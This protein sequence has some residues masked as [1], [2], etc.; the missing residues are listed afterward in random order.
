MKRPLCVIALVIAAAVLILL[1]VFPGDEYSFVSDR[2]TITIIGTVTGK[3]RKINSYSGELQSIVELKVMGE[4]YSVL[5]YMDPEK[6][7]E[8]GRAIKIKG[9]CRAFSSATNPG[10]FD[11]RSYYRI[12]K[13]A[14]RITDPEILEMSA[15]YDGVKESLFSLKLSMENILDKCMSADDAGVMKAVLLGDKSY[16]DENTRDIYKR[17]GIIHI[18]AVSGLHISI[19]GLAIYSLL[20][21]T[22]IGVIPS[23]A[24]AI[25]VMYM[26]GILC[27][28]ST[29]A[30]RA[31]I[32]F[33]VRLLADVIGR[34]YDM[35][36]ALALAA[37]LL[38][39]EQPLYVMH[40]GYLMSFGAVLAIGYV[41]P[42]LPAV[43]RDGR[44]KIMGAGISIALVTFPIYLSFYYTFP[45]YSII[46]NL[47]ILPLMTALLF[48]GIL[49]IIIG[50]L[51]ILPGQ[52]V[53]L[54]SHFI[55]KWFILC[56][57]AGDFL[58]GSTWYVGHAGSFRVGIYLMSLFAFV[59]LSEKGSK[60][61]RLSLENNMI[62][63]F[64]ITGEHKRK[65]VDYIR[66]FA[67]SLGFIILCLRVRP[68]L[69]I[70]M[71][72]V[73]QGDGIFIETRDSRYL[74]DG[75]STSKKDLA[76]YQL[77]PF[78]S[79]EGVGSIDA[80]ILT[81]EDEDHL[82]GIAGLFENMEKSRGSIRIR[83][84]ILP[85][86]SD[87]SKGM[88]YRNLV[89][90]AERLGV[91][92]HYIKRGDFI[93]D[94]NIEIEC[95]GPVEG[96]NTDEPNAYSTVLLLRYNGFKALFTGDVDGAGQDILRQYI[97]D[98]MYKFRDVTLLKVAHHGSRYTSDDEFL[99]MISPKISLISCGVDN[100]YG[101]PHK[102]LLERLKSVKTSVYVT[103]KNGA[104][105]LE[106]KSDKL[107][108]STFLEN[109]DQIQLLF[110]GSRKRYAADC[111]R[112]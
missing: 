62:K 68:E 76:K 19:I 16:L 72:D 77:V 93:D 22:T 43:F 109:R 85:D 23:A 86:V 107:K 26:Y 52:I 100:K 82:S 50:A 37:I 104:V 78:L 51:F 45:V 49:S 6:E 64:K 75:G 9:E 38:L 92:V 110:R 84:L 108:V 47:F 34:T 103:A 99:K 66:F 74:I 11:S 67:L 63:K 69:K 46:L 18:I 31:I 98:N 48:S 80:V 97:R 27:G 1:S 44:L 101:H 3:E 21:K 111:V 7:P 42:A 2:T 83:N 28:M 88:N 13:I 20:R 91:P 10:E 79:Y 39:A 12:L 105:T 29:S 65:I 94:K 53:A 14:Y 81:H 41:L 112:K 60:H 4:N 87:R 57:S 30:A 58:P 40:S 17:N 90:S 25:I 89:A 71:L 5:I 54:V 56:C 55:L 59:I 33:A 8:F 35:L 73:G 15:G 32:M 61:I 106:I 95:V 36:S 70:T 96:M 24:T 102:E